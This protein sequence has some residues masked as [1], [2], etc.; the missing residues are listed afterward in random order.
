MDMDLRDRRRSLGLR[1]EEVARAAGISRTAVSLIETGRL[2]PSLETRRALEQA[3]D[4]FTS[5]RRL[6][7]AGG[8]LPAAGLLRDLAREGLDYALTLDVAS[9]LL[10]RYQT[11]AT[12][13][14]YVRPI[15]RWEALLRRHGVR[16]AG[17]GERANLVLLRASDE[18]LAEATPEAGFALARPRRL[19]EDCA[20]LGGRHG[21]DAAR[22][23]LEFPAA[24]GPG[25]RLEA[26]SLLKVFEE[27]VART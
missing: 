21:L 26:D 9:W 20:R 17:V 14:A 12:A 27:V 11:P 22:L 19:L 10:T 15:G 25:L 24:G 4:P 18:V 8:A 1:Q 7:F 16:R 23:F 3:L 13:W 5:P 6:V 2:R